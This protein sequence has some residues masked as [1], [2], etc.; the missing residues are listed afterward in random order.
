MKSTAEELADLN[1]L[2]LVA[3]TERYAQVFGRPPRSR[4]R[5]AMF[6]RLAFD[7]QEKR[8]GGL[9]NVARARLDELLAH[10]ELPSVT[11]A[12]D[13]NGIAVGTV[14]ERQW[15]DQLVRCTVRG[16]GEYECGGRTFQ[17]L[18]A[19]ARSITGSA[20]SG[21]LFFGLRGRVK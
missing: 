9:S 7:L 13:R 2:D 1:A 19:V 18:S 10:V 11:P 5:D 16:V 12:T 21:A 3:M 14:L 20:W 17:S 4:N 6:K 15:R 8:L